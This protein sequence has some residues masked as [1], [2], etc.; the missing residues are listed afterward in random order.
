MKFINRANSKDGPKRHFKDQD[1][2]INVQWRQNPCGVG[3]EQ[4]QQQREYLQWT[5]FAGMCLDKNNGIG[6]TCLQITELQNIF[7][8]IR[9]RQP[10]E[11]AID[12]SQFSTEAHIFP[13]K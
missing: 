8:K 3:E 12:G 6:I 9:K 7:C 13:Y 11:C 1:I 2:E 5:K 10:A 4:G